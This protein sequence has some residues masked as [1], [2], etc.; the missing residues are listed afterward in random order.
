[1]AESLEIYENLRGFVNSVTQRSEGII[2]WT[3][4]WWLNDP[5][6]KYMLVKLDHFPN[7]RGEK[8][9]YLKPPPR[10]EIQPGLSWNGFLISEKKMIVHCYCWFYSTQ[11]DVFGVLKV[12]FY[13]PLWEITIFHQ[14]LGNMNLFSPITKQANLTYLCL[15]LFFVLNPLEG[16]DFSHINCWTEFSAR[17][18][19]IHCNPGILWVF[20]TKCAPTSY[21]RALWPLFLYITPVT[22]LPFTRVNP[23]K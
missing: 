1:M 13:F 20:P 22:H 10:K 18:H 4:S 8:K 9:T 15:Y 17:S 12:I 21:K 19:R 23:R 2:L 14:H 16:S 5:P 6:E 3:T 11:R 7:F